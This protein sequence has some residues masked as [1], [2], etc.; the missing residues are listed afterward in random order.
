MRPQ[1]GA[2]RGLTG[3]PSP[4]V[5][6]RARQPPA[7]RLPGPTAAPP[8]GQALDPRPS[9]TSWAAS[10]REGGEGTSRRSSSRRRRDLIARPLRRRSPNTR[11][12]SR[13]GANGVTLHPGSGEGGTRTAH[14]P[15]RPL[16]GRASGHTMRGPRQS[17]PSDV[18]ARSSVSGAQAAPEVA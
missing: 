8:L 1:E 12:L 18:A 17:S 5:P 15:R 6:D 16:R 7:S 2:E 4:R 3:D 10:E 9:L 13:S 14:G 11:T